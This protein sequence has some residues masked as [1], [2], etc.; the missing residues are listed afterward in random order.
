MVG[1]RL[2]ERDAAQPE[3]LKLGI[4]ELNRLVESVQENLHR[5]AVDLRPASL[6]HLGLVAALRQYVE[7][8]G[9]KHGLV[10]QFEAVGLGPE[11][12][13]AN[14]ETAI[15]RIVQEA[16]T[17]VIRHAHAT[18]VDVLLERRGDR[19]AAIVEDNGIG[20]DVAQSQTGRLGLFG[21]RER[22]EML[23]GTLLIES[24]ERGG[25]TL[26]VEVSCDS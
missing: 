11:R 1:L 14:I 8:L 20:F 25:T 17:N 12:L 2:L 9:D 7:N 4:A 24:S 6:D 5:L 22:A 13:P 19:L 23:G 15:Y 21:I 10:I 3:A 16:L 26:V 18:R